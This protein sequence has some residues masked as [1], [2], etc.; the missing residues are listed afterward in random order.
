MKVNNT[1]VFVSGDTTRTGHSEQSNTSGIAVRASDKNP[2]GKSIDGSALQEKFDPVAAKKEEAK[3]KAMKIVGDAFANELKMDDEL[4]A[5][6]E[7]I[8]AL[9]EEKGYA[10]GAIKEIE[11]NRA[12]LREAYAIEED[13]QE[14]KDLKLL[15]KEVR[16]R[17]PGSGVQLSK[18]EMDAIQKIKENGLSEYQQRSL[19]MLG[20]EAPYVDIVYEADK[21]IKLEN[22][23]V[24]ETKLER[25]KSHTMEDAQKQAEEVLEAAS[26]EAIGM[27]VDEAKEHIDEEAEEREEKAEAE[28][29]KQEEI[30][31]RIDAAKEKK[32]ENEEL[33]EE[34]LEK[35]QEVSI[36]ASD[37]NAAQQEIKDM[38]SKMKLI[39]EDIKGAAVDQ[40]L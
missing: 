5:R 40:S 15:E 34:I 25:L 7:R 19:E 3:K 1:S 27:L 32:K 24:R 36:G 17:F 35:V 29:E 9:Q 16:S 22:Q 2:N 8:K 21:E 20:H 33:T 28:K 6:R 4:S 39:E 11:D 12:A 23:I 14:E 13:S 37:V 10:S 26:K 18:E 38:M 31:A 30:E